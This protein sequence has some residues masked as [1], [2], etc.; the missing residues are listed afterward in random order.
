MTGPGAGE[1]TVDQRPDD[2]A[3]WRAALEVLGFGL[4]STDAEG[5]L[6]S[7]DDRFLEIHGIDPTADGVQARVLGQ[8]P[9]EVVRSAAD[10][11]A[12][13]AGNPLAAA[14]ERL[15][16]DPERAGDGRADVRLPDGRTI[17]IVA[18]PGHG[19]MAVL[20][21]RD[22]AAT[23]ATGEPPMLQR[24]LAHEVNNALGGMLAHLYLALSDME[25]SH[26]A[27]NWVESVNDAVIDLR[28]MI[29]RM[30]S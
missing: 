10:P 5:A 22:N 12:N 23:A 13:G 17:E 2:G 4:A 8:H 1:G 6:E 7:A 24:S 18:A 20:A 15:L 29:R 28:S 9:V 21:A 30:T 25:P 3:A 27:R 26:P 19:R 11:A 14:W 16:D